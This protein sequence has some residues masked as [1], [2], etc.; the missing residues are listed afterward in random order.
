MVGHSRTK[1]KPKES[2]AVSII[3]IRLS[4][5]GLGQDQV[6]D[7]AI[8]TSRVRIY[9]SMIDTVGYQ[10]NA[11]RADRVPLGALHIIPRNLQIE[12]CPLRLSN[13]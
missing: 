2:A 7:R 6:R 12:P 9:I 5:S 10:W 13:G 11:G 3:C 8:C 4:A 1:G